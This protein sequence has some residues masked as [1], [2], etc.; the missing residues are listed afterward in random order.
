MAGKQR[1]HYFRVETDIPAPCAVLDG[2]G[3][4][5][6]CEARALN[7][8]AGGA[9]LELPAPL[10]DGQLLRVTL[11]VHEPP[12]ELRARAR[13]VRSDG[14][15]VGIEFVGID[16]RTRAAVTRFVFAQAKELGVTPDYAPPGSVRAA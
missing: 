5:T 1:R 8:S 15:H 3:A 9:W 10:Q 13:V 11:R 7:L 12:L 14:A 16:A 2:P 6:L 4:S